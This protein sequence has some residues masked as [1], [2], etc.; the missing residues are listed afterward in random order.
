MRTLLRVLLFLGGTVLLVLLAGF[1]WLYFYSRDLPDISSLAQYAPST[2][3]RVSDSCIGTSIA[4][5]YEAIGTNVR[6]AISA[7][8]TNE[9]D[10]GVLSTTFRGLVTE[11]PRRR[12]TTASWYISRTMCRAPSRELRRQLA[13]LRTAIQLERHYSR[14]ELFTMFTNRVYLGPI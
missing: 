8:E 1:C 10:P 7:S 9:N 2:E 3:T 6:N 12:T 14:R 11:E 13:E 5:P 4:I